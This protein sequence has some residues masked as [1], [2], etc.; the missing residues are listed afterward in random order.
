[1]CVWKI[2]CS[3]DV[4]HHITM[5][6]FF[7]G[8]HIYICWVV[9][10]INSKSAKIQN[11]IVKELK[12]VSCSNLSQRHTA[13]SK[14]CSA[15]LHC[16]WLVFFVPS[17]LPKTTNFAL[18]CPLVKSPI[19][20]VA[21]HVPCTINMI[22]VFQQHFSWDLA[23]LRLTLVLVVLPAAEICVCWVQAF[24]DDCIVLPGSA[25]HTPASRIY[26]LDIP[27]LQDQSAGWGLD[28]SQLTA[29][30]NFCCFNRHKKNSDSTQII[31]GF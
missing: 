20:P 10:G 1:M 25:R 9:K 30:L 5:Y 6:L 27:Q 19:V 24:K 3:L 21:P 23:R 17:W 4:S 7:Q 11:N 18:W 22:V 8:H 15:R 14:W 29:V 16:Q 31:L 28:S 13:M 12:T 26:S 2:M